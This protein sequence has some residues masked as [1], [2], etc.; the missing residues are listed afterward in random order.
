MYPSRI[1]ILFFRVL[2]G[3]LVAQTGRRQPSPASAVVAQSG[4]YQLTA[5]M[6]QQ[7]R[8]RIGD[9]TPEKSGSPLT[10]S[11]CEWV[12]R[13]ACG[14]F[15]YVCRAQVRLLSLST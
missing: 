8:C 4:G 1:T 2:I 10:W 11:Q 6:L 13:M 5:Q 3:F 14:G 7:Y 12:R 15:W 9:T